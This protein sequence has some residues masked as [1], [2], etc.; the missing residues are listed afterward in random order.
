MEMV[1]AVVTAPTMNALSN[2]PRN[3]DDHAGL[4][5]TLVP[6]ICLVERASPVS[7]FI[8]TRIG[9]RP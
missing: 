9:H 7:N 2:R 1:A 3:R 8:Q 6:L 4:S 5:G